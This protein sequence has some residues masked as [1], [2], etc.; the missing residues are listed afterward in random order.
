[1][2]LRIAAIFAHPDDEVLAC[3]GTMAAHAKAGHEVRSLILATGLAS[4][5]A[6]SDN[7]ISRLR[8]HGEAASR[9]IHDLDKIAVFLLE[10]SFLEQLEKH[11]EKHVA[12]ELVHSGGKLYVTLPKALVEGSITEIRLTP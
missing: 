1:M 8:A 7:A 6:A 3:G 9:K 11:L 5:G 12:L 2:T 4:R 10:Q